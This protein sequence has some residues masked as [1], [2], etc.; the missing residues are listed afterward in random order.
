MM[1][2]ALSFPG[3]V[4]L[5]R[6]VLRGMAAAIFFA[7]SWAGSGC[8]PRTQI[9]IESDP[10][11]AEITCN[12]KSCP[13]APVTLQGLSGGTYLITAAK[14][15]YRSARTVVTIQ[16]GQRVTIPLKLEPLQGLVR[17]TSAP[18]GADVSVD[19]AFK[20]KTP[21]F[22]TDLSMGKHRISFTATGHLAREIEISLED[23]IP[24]AVHADLPLNAGTLSVRSNPAGATVVLNG[25][26]RGVT[27]AEITDAPAGDNTLEIRLSGYLPASQPLTVVAQES[28][29]ISVNLAPL[30]TRLL[31]VS[32]PTGA[33]MY[34]DNEFKGLTPLAL[35][36][37]PPGARRIRAEMAGYE[38]TARTIELKANENQTEE[39]RMAKNSGK[40]LLVTE[41]AG[42]KVFLNG[43][44]RGQTR[45]AEHALISDPIELDLLPPGVYQL[46]LNRAGYRHAPKTITLEANQVVDLHEKMV[47]LYVPDTRITLLS[48]VVREGM[49]L[50]EYPGGKI[51]LQLETGTI[52]TID[53]GEVLRKERLRGDGI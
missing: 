50:H 7:A 42:V 47:R 41:P 45:S 2:P 33:R 52:I 28:R 13:H 37:L 32:L 6:L 8:G 19:G 31:L 9:Q 20:G 10:N 23:A 16:E 3:P 27:P 49:L 1:K 30:P 46:Q 40:I 29:E 22:L 51:D 12:G 44:E 39:F 5:H 34:V 4:P 26:E 48:G 43:E 11:G 21:A 53:K 24:R 14:P 38:V 15:G 18:A 17:I 35:K 25:V 36:D